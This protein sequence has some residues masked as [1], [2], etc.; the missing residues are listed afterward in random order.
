MG[1]TENDYIGLFDGTAGLASGSGPKA[2]GNV[3]S[4][5]ECTVPEAER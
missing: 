2:S 1:F 4:E 5:G 3:E